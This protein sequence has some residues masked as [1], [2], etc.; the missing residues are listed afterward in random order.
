M[1]TNDRKITDLMSDIHSGKTQLPDFQRGWVWDDNRIKALIASISSGYPVGA[2]MFLEYGN[3]NIRFKYRVIEGSPRTNATPTELILDGQQRLTS[4]YSSLF[5]EKAV[6]TRTDKGQEIKRFYYIDMEKAIDPSVDRI[7][8]VISVPETRQVTSDFGRKIDIDLSTP[9]LEYEQKLFPLNNILDPNKYNKW[10]LGFMQHHHFEAATSMLYTDFL[11]KI[12]VPLGQY[13]IPVI[14]L[15]K[16][17]PKEAVCQV[18][19]NVNTGGVSLT[20]FELITAIFAMDD[21]ELRKDW[22]YRRQKYFTGDLLSITSSTDFLTACTLLSTYKKGGTV[23]CKKKDVLNLTLNEYQKYSDALSEGFVEAEKLLQEERIFSSKD[24]PYSTQLIPLA[25]LCTLLADNNQIKIANIKDKLKKWYWCGVFGEMYGSANETRYVNDVVGVMEWL[26]DPLRIPK[27]IQESYFNPVRLLSLQSR[28]SA[29]YKGIMALILKNHCRDF[30][31]G[32]EMDFTVYKAESIDIHHIFPKDHCEKMGYPRSKWNSVVNKTPI[33]YSTNRE[34][35]GVA[36][37]QY[38]ARIEKKGQVSP[39][40]LDEYLETHMIDVSCCRTDD[41]NQ[42]FTRRAISIL[43]AIEAA[44][45]KAIAGRDSELVMQ[46]FGS[47]LI[48]T[49]T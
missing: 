16:D 19:E 31:S 12:I 41:F 32:R 49:N 22:S 17:T 20:V 1:K 38:L 42:Y 48:Q 21:F 40:T 47:S 14:T 27:T 28:Q 11:T 45:G 8:A 30:I 36:P 39:T 23:S 18:F 34:I 4:I 13:T 6:N 10:Q 9:T 3:E 5:S 2:A 37:S 43:N 44:T 35:G 46:D 7:D 29:A 33:S 15:D 24:L 26:N 25:V